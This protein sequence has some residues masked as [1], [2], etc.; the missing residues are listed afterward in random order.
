[1]LETTTSSAAHQSFPKA[2]RGAIREGQFIQI[3]G[4]DD[5]LAARAF[6]PTAFGATPTTT[7]L[8]GVATED[9]PIDSKVVRVSLF[10]EIK[11]QISP[12]DTTNYN[13]QTASTT[14]TVNV[15]PTDGLVSNGVAGEVPVRKRQNLMTFAAGTVYWAN[16]KRF[17]R[18]FI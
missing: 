18:V 17:A 7:P 13:A 6:A 16:G 14:Y 4:G 1:M 11:V 2:V 5:E 15:N 8:I 9:S 10:G 12:L 3:G